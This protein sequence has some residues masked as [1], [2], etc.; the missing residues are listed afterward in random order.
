MK[1]FFKI[2]KIFLQSVV[3]LFLFLS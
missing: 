3:F 2:F 1:I